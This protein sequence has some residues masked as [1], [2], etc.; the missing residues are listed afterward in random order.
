MKE[1][2]LF[3]IICSFLYFSNNGYTLGIRDIYN[4]QWKN[5]VNEINEAHIGDKVIIKFETRNI[6]DN[7]IINIEIWGKTNNDLMDL[8]NN[9]QG[10]VINNNIE[11]EW[12]I[13]F[14]MYNET[15]NYTR[16]IKNNGYAIIDYIFIVKYND[17]IINSKYL[18]ILSWLDILVTNKETGKPIINSKYYVI[19][20]DNE[21]MEGITDSNGYIIVRNIRKI[22]YYKIII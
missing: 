5:E 21:I 11:I 2:K 14:D 1:L 19:A 3:F 22:G 20:P 17:K 7:E 16:E 12:I 18:E 4:L 8:I 13:E 9:I 15:F 10:T 6:P